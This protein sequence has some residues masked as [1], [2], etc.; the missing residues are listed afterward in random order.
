MPYWPCDA[1]NTMV[2]SRTIGRPAG[3]NLHFYVAHPCDFMI[4]CQR[5]YCPGR[6]GTRVAKLQRRGEHEHVPLRNRHRQRRVPDGNGT[7]G[8]I[9]AHQV[10]RN[11]KKDQMCSQSVR[12]GSK[13][14]SIRP[15]EEKRPVPE[16]N[17]AAVRAATRIT[18][19]DVRN[20]AG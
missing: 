7:G 17:P 3:R 13:S 19:D 9:G 5:G 6:S 16:I 12:K 8:A 2:A 15:G 11:V 4:H 14:R 20:N 1:A 10:G 18:R